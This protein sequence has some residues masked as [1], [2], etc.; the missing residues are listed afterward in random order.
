VRYIKKKKEP[1]TVLVITVL[2]ITVLVI[3]VLVITV[4]VSTVLVSTVLVSTIKHL[5][6]TSNERES[7]IVDRDQQQ[8]QLG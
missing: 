7:K 8:E 4:L 6:R 5:K 3:T 2:V 1:I